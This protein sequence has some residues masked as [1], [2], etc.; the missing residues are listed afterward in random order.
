M[1]WVD[2]ERNR[3][4]PSPRP[5][6]IGSQRGRIDAGHHLSL[7]QA[8]CS[9]AS[10]SLQRSRRKAMPLTGAPSAASRPKAKPGRCGVPRAR[11]VQMQKRRFDSHPAEPPDI[12]QCAKQGLHMKRSIG[13][14]PDTALGIV[15]LQRQAFPARLL[16]RAAC[17]THRLKGPKRSHS[18]RIACLTRQSHRRQTSAESRLIETAQLAGMERLYAFVAQVLHRGDANLANAGRCAG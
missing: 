7:P 11:A 2:N 14:D 12:S 9:P 17:V 3:T 18:C 16:A 1:I 4:S 13:E 10:L 6:A 15:R 8:G 5:C